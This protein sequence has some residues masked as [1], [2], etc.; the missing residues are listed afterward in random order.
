MYWWD[1]IR[2]MGDFKKNAKNP[3]FVQQQNLELQNAGKYFI[4]NY[5]SKIS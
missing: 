4:D 3:D 1:E 5:K 2:E